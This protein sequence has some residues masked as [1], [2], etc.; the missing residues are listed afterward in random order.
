MRIDQPT[1]TDLTNVAHTHSG[2]TSGG[3]LAQSNTHE[4]ADTDLTASSIHHTL[5]IDGTMASNSDAKVPSQKAIV[6]YVAANSGGGGGNIDGG[7]ANTVYQL[8]DVI[9]G[10][11][12]GASL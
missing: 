1:I 5:D 9:D 10:G 6:T 4:T 7:A 2:T 8:S 12:G 3:K 11:T